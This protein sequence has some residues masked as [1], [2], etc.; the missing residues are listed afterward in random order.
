MSKQ[1][2]RVVIG[3]RGAPGYEEEHTFKGYDKAIEM[4]ADYIEQDLQLTQDG[5]LVISHDGTVDRMTDGEGKIKDMT[6]A[7]IKRF[8][9]PEGQQILTLDEL[10]NEYGNDIKYYIETKRPHDPDMDKELIRILKKHNLI[11]MDKKKEQ[12]VIQSFSDESLK[13]L[14]E[15]YSDMFYVQLTKT[16]K[17][18]DLEAIAEYASGVGPKF[19]EIDK[20]F[21]DN[22]HNAG[23]LVHPYTINKKSDMED[24]MAMGVDGFFTNYTDRGVEVM[25][26]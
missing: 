26:G 15:Q 7:E 5:H 17:D 22:A 12:V 16:P 21:V 23:L 2:R 14:H 1:G 4:G 6:L 10:I 24:A 18:E 13:N 20:E 8:R 3:H 9:T 19:A 25:K 11:G